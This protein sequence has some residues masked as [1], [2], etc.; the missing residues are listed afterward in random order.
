MFAIL[1][2]SGKIGRATIE[3][4][5]AQGAPV[6]AVLRESSNKADLEALGCEIAFADLYDVGSISEAIHG[7]N[8]L[9]VICPPNN[10]AKDATSEMAQIIDAIT[11]ALKAGHPEKVLAI[12]DYGAQVDSGTGIT[13]VFHYME[14]RLSTV[15][16][17]LIFLRSAEH[18]Q[19]WGR[20]FKPALET[21]ML[22]SFHH[23]LSKIFPT[24]SAP[25]V[26]VIAAELL[27]QPPVGA[28]PR[29]VH[30]EGPRRYSAAD[31]A[32][33]LSEV[34]GRQ[35][36]AKE[37]PESEWI[38]VL[39]RAGSSESYANTIRELYVAHNAGRIDVE[40]GGEVR[41]GTT[42]LGE[43]FRALLG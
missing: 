21:G 12:S 34:S 38:P 25:D 37:I 8:V 5:R 7:A 36:V 18:M 19:N 23:P 29:I 27:L 13:M 22:P 42:E 33:I 15:P 6:R 32:A 31:V 30:A 40:P 41:L 43:A 35:I 16:G 4:L 2:A 11:A 17:A 1:G 39:T 26:G 14:A 9:Q 20:V 28:S 24:V 3:K 10:R